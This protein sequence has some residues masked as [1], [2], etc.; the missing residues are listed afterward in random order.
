MRCGDAG[1]H[2]VGGEQR[3]APGNEVG[4]R[5]AFARAFQDLVDDIGDGLWVIE[6]QALRLV[7]SRK[8]GGDIDRQPFHFR[9]GQ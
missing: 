8:L 9:W 6:R 3:R 2:V 5:A 1:H 7:L 4:H